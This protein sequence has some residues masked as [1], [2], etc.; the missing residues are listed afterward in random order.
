MLL[1]FLRFLS[2]RLTKTNYHNII[3]NLLDVLINDSILFCISEVNLVALY[4]IVALHE[5]NK[6]NIVLL[7]LPILSSSVFSLLTA[8]PILWQQILW[9]FQHIDCMKVGS[10]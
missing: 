9:K 10:N 5:T 4:E 1:F 6:P 3:L 2:E 7:C 8:F